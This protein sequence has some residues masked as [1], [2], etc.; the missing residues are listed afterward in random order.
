MNDDLNAI[1]VFVALAEARSFRRAG[2]SL[3]VTASAVSQSLR[4]L[5][6]RLGVVLAHRTSRSMHLTEA[7][8][9]LYASVRPALE[10]VR[11]AAAAVGALGSEPRGTLRL[12][13]AGGA[14]TFLSGP[15]IAGF[16]EAHPY[17]R[18]QVFVSDEPL[19]IVS[20]G[21]DAGVRLGEVIDVDM[22]TVPLAGDE[23]LLV[24]GTPA[25]FERH[26][27]PAHPRDLVHHDCL[28]WH[29]TADAPAYRWE[30]TEDGRDFSVAVPNRVLTNQV[31]LLL[32]LTRAGR[33]LTMFF[34][35]ELRADIER[36]DLV[37]VLEEYSIPF[38]GFFLYYP[39]R[40]Q[41]SPA[42]RAFVDYTLA[43]RRSSRDRDSSS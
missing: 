9:L 16:L 1:S 7:G 4:R 2:E 43:W 5:E 30:F 32:H 40:R 20:A 38:P 34:E 28:N 15:I 27:A 21:Y 18:V 33:G 17:V 39:E 42:L 14:E 24:V 22:A 29:P 6:E 35:R 36:G 37:V 10:E 26:P 19:D 25:Y 3:G 23:R 31:A 41:A 12:H 8:E 13:V 11:A